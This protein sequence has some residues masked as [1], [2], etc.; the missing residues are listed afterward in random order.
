MPKNELNKYYFDVLY[1][2]LKRIIWCEE[3]KYKIKECNR[4]LDNILFCDICIKTEYLIPY[5]LKQ[6][7]K[8]GKGC[9]ITWIPCKCCD[10]N[11]CPDCFSIQN[12]FHFW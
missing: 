8:D 11:Y 7:I 3:W 6:L 12:K 1:N 10:K 4:V 5:T 2:D 9:N